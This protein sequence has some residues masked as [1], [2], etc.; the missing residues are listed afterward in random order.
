MKKN[1]L[2]YLMKSLRYNYFQTGSFVKRNIL[3]EKVDKDMLDGIYIHER[4]ASALKIPKRF[5]NN[6]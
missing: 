6:E 2:N 1:D 4:L 3:I 5:L